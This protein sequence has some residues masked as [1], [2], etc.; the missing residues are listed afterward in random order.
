MIH[1]QYCGNDYSESE[2]CPVCNV[3]LTVEEIDTE[4]DELYRIEHAN[5]PYVDDHVRHLIYFLQDLRKARQ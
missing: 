2:I 5:I 3:E 4:L 1:C